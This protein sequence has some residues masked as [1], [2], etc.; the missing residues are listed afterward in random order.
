MAIKIHQAVHK[1]INRNGASLWLPSNIVGGRFNLGEPDIYSQSVNQLYPFAT[2]LEYADGRVFRYGKFGAT[3]T[4]VPLA[5]MVANMN[6][7]GAATGYVADDGFEGNLY[8]AAPAGQQY[9]DL[10]TIIAA[11]GTGIR[12][13]VYAENFF[14]DGML[15]V[16][17][18]GHYCEYRICG[19]DA[20]VTP[21]T[22]CYLDAPLKT[23]LTVGTTAAY[24]TTGTL[25][26][27]TGG[28]GV[29]AYAS[30]FSQ[31]KDAVAEGTGF[32]SAV[33][34]CLASGFT[35]GYFGWIQR[36]GRCI[37]TPTAYFGD[38]ADERMAQLHSDG[39]IALKA[40]H[41]THTI[42]YLTSRT[43]SGYGDLEVWLMFE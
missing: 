36:K 1:I 31:L 13:T 10:W 9:V 43:V 11:S 37:I 14:E 4:N 34:A 40:A 15:A 7:C 6:A 29:T 5:R 3:S 23:A 25:T 12:T 28:S 18:D 17:P 35:S 24:V 8:A 39:C 21:Y 33:G 42:G 27:S 19:N 30:L 26:A 41:G 32:I 20:T 2:K 16:Y 22:R 38:T